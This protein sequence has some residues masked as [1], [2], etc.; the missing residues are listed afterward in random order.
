MA[1]TNVNIEVDMKELLSA[2]WDNLTTT[3]SSWLYSFSFDWENND[4]TESVVVNFENPYGDSDVITVVTPEMLLKAFT[5]CYGKT[6]WGQVVNDELEFDTLVSDY[7]L[8][9]AIFG[10]EVFG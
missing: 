7:I 1:T 8:Q 10:E 4:G 2:V 6:I 3:Y 9:I 5:E